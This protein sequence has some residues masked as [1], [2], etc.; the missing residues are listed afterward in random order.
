MP[1]TVVTLLRVDLSKQCAA[2][3]TV[4]NLT[5]PQALMGVSPSA[6]CHIDDA[7]FF[8]KATTTTEAMQE[9]PAIVTKG[10]TGRRGPLMAVV[11]LKQVMRVGHAKGGGR[12]HDDKII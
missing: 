2:G 7:L 8:N 10:S 1:S 5:G 3:A 11:D 12:K 6:H 4:L 9:A